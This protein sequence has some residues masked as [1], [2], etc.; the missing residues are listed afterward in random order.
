[1]RENFI[2]PHHLNEGSDYAYYLCH[3]FS[4]IQE[5]NKNPMTMCTL[6]CA[7]NLW[8]QHN[9]FSQYTDYDV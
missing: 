4:I 5:D 8:M 7:H 1:M 6:L 3:F 9:F 2:E